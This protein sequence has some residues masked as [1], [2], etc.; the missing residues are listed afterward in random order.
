MM[1]FSLPVTVEYFSEKS[2]AFLFGGISRQI[3]KCDSAFSAPLR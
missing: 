1:A 3:K 2:E